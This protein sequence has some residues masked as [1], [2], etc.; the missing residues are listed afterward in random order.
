MGVYTAGIAGM[1]RQ[2]LTTARTV[3][4]SLSL[5]ITQNPPVGLILATPHPTPHQ[6]TR[7]DPF[8]LLAPDVTPVARSN[9]TGNIIMSSNPGG[10]PSRTDRLLFHHQLP[11]AVKRA[12]CLAFLC[13]A[14]PPRPKCSL[15]NAQRLAV[16][17]TQPIDMHERLH[18]F[19]AVALL[20]RQ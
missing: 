2:A 3:W 14:S 18:L 4:Y 9:A 16:N 6:G 11:N 5:S 1:Q 19:L 10:C 12:P 15:C 13:P 17:S 20:G 8:R 7:S